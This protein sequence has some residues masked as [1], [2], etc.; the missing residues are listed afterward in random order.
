MVYNKS[1]SLELF[2]IAITVV[3]FIAGYLFINSL[4]RELDNIRSSVDSTKSSVASSLLDTTRDISSRLERAS[5][6]IGELKKETGAFSE[7]GRSMKDLQDYLRSPKLR[8]N[9]GEAVLAD[10]IGQ[11]FPKS[12]YVLQY[13]FKSGEKVDAIVKTDAGILPIDSKFPLENFQKI[14]SEQNPDLVIAHRRSFVR[15]VRLHVKTISTKYINPSEGT[16]D[17]ALMYIPSESVYYE[18]VQ[19]D[20]VMDY[21]RGL[22]VYP[23]SPSTLYAALQTILLSFE[24]RRI[25][26]RAKEVFTLLRSIQKDYTKVSESYSTLGTHLTNAY[27]KYSEVSSGITQLGQKLEGT[28][29]LTKSD[30][31]EQPRIS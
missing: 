13:A 20:G 4:R 10:L 7:I 6:V 2:L 8:G 27:N 26:S 31:D 30:S 28:K 9:I 24:G 25:E 1:M 5:Y 3:I 21:A 11:I 18:I 16:L 23:V 14:Y 17:F 22:R 12:S 29:A 19:A 15:D